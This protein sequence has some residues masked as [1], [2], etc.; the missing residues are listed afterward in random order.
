MLV[1]L[2]IFIYSNRTHIKEWPKTSAQA[3]KSTQQHVARKEKITALSHAQISSGSIDEKKFKLV[4]LKAD[5][6]SIPL[7]YPSNMKYDKEKNKL[8]E[9]ELG[10]P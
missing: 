7:F 5:H 2:Q 4:K 10:K 3:N 6:K 9:I 8:T 1:V